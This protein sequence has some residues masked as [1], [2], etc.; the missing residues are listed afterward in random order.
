MTES[1]SYPSAIDYSEAIQSPRT[2]FSEAKLKQGQVATDKKLGVPLSSAGNFAVVYQMQLPSQMVAVRCFTRPPQSDQQERYEALSHHLK[3]FWIPELV[4]F[5]YIVQG[6]KVKERWYPIVQMDW[7]EGP[8]LDSYVKSC[9]HQPDRLSQLAANWRGVAASLR[10]GHTAHGDLQHGNIKVDSQGTIRLVDYDGLFIPVLRGRPPN[11]VGLPNYQHP[12]RIAHG[13]YDEN[14]DAFSSLV[15][16]LSLIALRSNA[17]LW[18][19]ELEGEALL[20]KADDYKAPGRTP[21]W[22]KLRQSADE[23]VRRLTESLEHFCSRPVS[24]LPVLEELLQA[25]RAREVV[26]KES[27]KNPIDERQDLQAEA[28]AERIPQVP[29]LSLFEEIY[30]APK[31]PVY[32]PLADPTAVKQKRA[33]TLS[34]ASR[35]S[36]VAA[37]MLTVVFVVLIQVVNAQRATQDSLLFNVTMLTLLLALLLGVVAL[38]TGLIVLIRVDKKQQNHAWRYAV[39]GIALGLLPLVC[40]C[41]SEISSRSAAR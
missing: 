10:G 34:K 40:C 14:A 41:I 27:E 11:E 26:T 3:Q 2:R 18:I 29:E 39:F 12:E 28:V 7:I 4:D 17:K 19:P 20:F 32:T 1:G 15:I 21:I 25:M 38:I 31:M 37:A 6:I 9:L 30:S 8:L 35:R 5:A 24:E 22:Q 13:Y 36:G 33:Q 16:Y 23:E